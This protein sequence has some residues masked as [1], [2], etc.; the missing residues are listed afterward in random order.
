MEVKWKMIKDQ[1][2][3]E[4]HV[5]QNIFIFLSKKNQLVILKI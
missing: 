5:Q 2:I 4:L 3:L 1:I